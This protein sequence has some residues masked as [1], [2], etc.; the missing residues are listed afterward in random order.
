MR[1]PRFDGQIE[2]GCSHIFVVQV[3]PPL[4]QGPIDKIS[5]VPTNTIAE[6]KTSVFDSSSSCIAPWVFSDLV[7][8]A[9]TVGTL[10][11]MSKHCAGLDCSSQ[12]CQEFHQRRVITPPSLPPLRTQLYKLLAKTFRSHRQ[13]LFRGAQSNLPHVRCKRREHPV[14]VSSLLEP[15]RE[16]VNGK[17]MS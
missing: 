5:D 13:I 10:P 3:I 8:R 11:L 1:G 15:R 9:Q 2:D 12:F 6:P 4:T 16:T 7:L 17:R 14:Q